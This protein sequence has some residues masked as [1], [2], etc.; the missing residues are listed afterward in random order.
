[1]K[2]LL[3]FFICVFM[4]LSCTNAEKDV[5][6][7]DNTDSQEQIEAEPQFK[8]ETIK[9]SEELEEFMANT[10]HS[11]K[12]LSYD[13]ISCIGELYC[14]YVN[15]SFNN[16]FLSAKYELKDK[17]GEI[18]RVYLIDNPG[19]NAQYQGVSDLR[20]YPVSNEYS[21]ASFKYEDVIYQY[22]FPTNHVGEGRLA[23]IL[24]P[25]TDK[26]DSYI[27]LVSEN[28]SFSDYPIDGEETFISRLLNAD[29]VASAKAELE[30]CILGE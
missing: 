11:E 24:L 18:I 29:T 2:Q 9:D 21:F 19:V 1:M 26:S 13:K 25:F 28:G 10:K 12:Y 8:I 20:N 14:A 22:S 30:K 16:I 4:M 7:S 23:T 27:L 6:V 5:S 3:V 15:V 17:N